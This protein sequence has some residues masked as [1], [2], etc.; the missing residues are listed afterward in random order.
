MVSVVCGDASLVDIVF[1]TS[2]S[3]GVADTEKALQFYKSIVNE[4]PL[5]N[6]NIHIGMSRLSS[7][8]LVPGNKQMIRPLE[9]T[10]IRSWSL[11]MIW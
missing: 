6:D 1:S 9:H 4:L 7:L 11:W 5:H 3:A 10:C 8:R 2:P